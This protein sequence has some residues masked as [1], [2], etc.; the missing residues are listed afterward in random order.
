MNSTADERIPISVLMPVYNAEQY[1]EEAIES[2]LNQTWTDFEFLI[3]ND[4]SSDGSEEIIKRYAEKDERIKW[5]SR[6]NR[7]LSRTLNEL[8]SMANGKYLARMDADDS[9]REDRLEIQY[10]Y[11]EKHTEVS[12]LG[13]PIHIMGTNE[14]RMGLFYDSDEVRGIR[15]MFRNAGVAHPTAF[16][17]ASFI[18]D[19]KIRY[20]EDNIGSE[21]YQLWCDIICAG[22]VISGIKHS[23]LDYRIV[24]GSM[25]DKYSD[26]GEEGINKAKEQLLR[27]F[28]KFTDEEISE[29]CKFFDLKHTVNAEVLSLAFS[30]IQSE[31]KKKGLYDNGLLKKEL[32]LQWAWSAALRVKHQRNFSM[33]RLRYLMNFIPPNRWG[34]ILKNVIRSK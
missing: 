20:D 11:M 15:L 32:G 16:L 17:R 18:F 22:G 13:S 3:I 7:G 5:R 31:N 4:G 29:I 34:Y 1:L 23:L 33:L 19:N 25:S 8:L 14:T 9:S 27:R 2:I 12:V 21:D 24:E 6:C 28:G 26:K 30:K 10:Q